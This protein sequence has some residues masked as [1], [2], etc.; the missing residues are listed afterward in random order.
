MALAA[1]G[2]LP[3]LHGFEQGRLGLR[4]SAVDLVGEYQVG[5]DRA[6]QELEDPLARALVLLQHLRAGDVGGHQVRGELDP[7]EGHLQGAGQRTDHQ[8]LGQT[9]HA[10]ENAVAAGENG[11]QEQVNDLFLADD[12]LGQL[13]PEPGV[14]V[15]Y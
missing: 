13:A 12:R 6:F 4:G 14:G 11:Q 7:G 10:L 15:L 5:E 1:D 3:L 8:R 9:G 2:D